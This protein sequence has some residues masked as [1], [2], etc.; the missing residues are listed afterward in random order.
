MYA[1]NRFWLRFANQAFELKDLDVYEKHFTVMN[2]SDES[3]L[4]Q[5]F[6]QDFVRDFE[7]QYP[8]ISW[9]SVE[10]SIFKMFK[11]PKHSLTTPKEV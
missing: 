2:Y 9:A 1:Y 4:K 7:A 6:C 10:Q 11:V 8:Q 3:D 5:M